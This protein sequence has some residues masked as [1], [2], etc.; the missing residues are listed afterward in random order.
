MARCAS[1]LEIMF[2][3]IKMHKINTTVHLLYAL[4][5]KKKEKPCKD[6]K[7]DSQNEK[8]APSPWQ[9]EPLALCFTDCSGHFPIPPWP[10]AQPRDGYD[11]SIAQRGV[12]AVTQR[13]DMQSLVGQGCCWHI[14]PAPSM[15]RHWYLESLGFWGGGHPAEPLY[16]FLPFLV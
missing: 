16:S 9:Q 5:G 11:H 14:T 15:H 7:T 12:V 13:R 6:Y 2:I 8:P 4:T 1:S 10:A 3:A